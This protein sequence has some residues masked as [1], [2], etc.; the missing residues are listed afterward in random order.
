MQ[1]NTLPREAESSHRM[2]ALL[3]CVS[4]RHGATRLCLER[5]SSDRDEPGIGVVALVPTFMDSCTIIGA[6]P[7]ESVTTP[8]HVPILK[9]NS[10]HTPILPKGKR[11]NAKAAGFCLFQALLR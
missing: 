9:Q 8:S 3:D 6:L 4:S 2:A 7:S 10:H 1:N 11:N 5:P